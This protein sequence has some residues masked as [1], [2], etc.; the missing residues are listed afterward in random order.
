MIISRYI[1]GNKHGVNLSMMINYGAL[2]NAITGDKR[3]HCYV[4]RM[5]E[6]LGAA[7]YSCVMNNDAQLSGGFCVFQK[8]VDIIEMCN[9][10]ARFVSLK[11]VERVEKTVI[12]SAHKYLY[13]QRTNSRDAPTFELRR[14]KSRKVYSETEFSL[15]ICNF[16]AKGMTRHLVEFGARRKCGRVSIWSLR[17]NL[18]DAHTQAYIHKFIFYYS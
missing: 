9:C 11:R 2:I 6:Y 7:I 5:S 4:R 1:R 18:S 16:S 8:H 15:R 14:I 3:V 10:K 13:S 12:L 17:S